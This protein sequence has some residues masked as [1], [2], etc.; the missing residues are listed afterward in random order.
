MKTII[1]YETQA[2]ALDALAEY[3]QTQETPPKHAHEGYASWSPEHY[4]AVWSPDTSPTKSGKWE[5]VVR[6]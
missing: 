3:V 5:L 1:G 6:K 2:D 4:A